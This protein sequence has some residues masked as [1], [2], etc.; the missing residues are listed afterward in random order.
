MSVT[1]TYTEYKDKGITGLANLGNTCFMNTALQCISHCYEFNEILNKDSLE[2]NLN[3]E[4]DSKLLKE[5]NELRKLMWNQNAIVKPGGF[6]MNL[7]TIARRKGRQIFTGFAQNDLPEFLYFLIDCFHNSMKREVVMK[8]QGEI[9]TTQDVIAKKCLDMVKAMY[10]KEYSEVISLFY[11]VQVSQILDIE[12]PKKILSITPEPYFI[13]HLP[14]PHYDNTSPNLPTI[15]DCMDLYTT[16]EHL[17]DDNKWYN[18]KT[19]SHQEVYKKLNFFSFPDVLII[20]LKRFTNMGRKNQVMVEFPLDDLDLQKYV[21]YQT[22][23][24][25]TYELFGVCN[26]TGSTMGGHY[27]AYIKTA[28][29]KWYEFNDTHVTEMIKIEKIVS[30]KAYCLFYRRKK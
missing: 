23:K 3:N 1:E 26:H 10:E 2:E 20:D 17:T 24:S 11:G 25:N 9:K 16:R 27:F 5:W 21:L 13:L 12:E 30:P 22:T 18:D 19:K 15:Y 6:V 29:G 28:S 14:I 7:H 4:D 8:V